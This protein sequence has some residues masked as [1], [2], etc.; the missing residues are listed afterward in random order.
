MGPPAGID[1][2]NLYAST[3]AVEAADIGAARGTDPRDL[4]RLKLLR[5]S[6]A[7]AFEDPVTLA[8]NAAE[9]LVEAAGR[10]AFELLIVASESGVDYGKPLSSYVHRHL[11]LGERCR[12]VE[13]KHACY[14]GTAALQLATSWVR[15]QAGASAAA[16]ARAAGASPRALVC[17]TDMARRI[18]GDPAEP[19][20][21]AGAVALAVAAEP[22]VLALEPTSGYAA[23]EVYDVTR[24]TPVLERANASLSLGAYL[25]LLEIASADY[26]RR[27]GGARLEE[28]FAAIAYHTPLVPLVEQ[29]HRTLIEL[30][31]EDAS[32]DRVAASF[33]RLVRPSLGFCREIGNIYS[34]SLYAAL[35]G[36][37]VADPAL[38]P[39]ARVGLYSYGSGSCAEMFSG[40]VGRE[41]RAL[42]ASRRIG[43]RL[44][45][46]RLASVAEYERCVLDTERSLTAADFTPDRDAPAGLFEASYRGRGLLVLEGVRDYYRSYVRS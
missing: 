18:F 29:A 43:E 34:G 23:R 26:R 15:A 13:L 3:L 10:D 41:A 12:N 36:R 2:L 37:L 35:A 19:A 30:E 22:R 31:D 16:G 33:D 28:H 24:P 45:A 9:P 11:G 46:R 1:D 4:G 40:T 38:A 5:R 32:A 8:V 6:L 42:V 25:D 14:A 44:A 7:P 17:M 39:G 27:I 20:E 21:G